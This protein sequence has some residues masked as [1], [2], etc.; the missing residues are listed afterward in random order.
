MLGSVLADVALMHLPDNWRWMVGLPVLP[1]AVLAGVQ[2][3]LCT[4]LPPIPRA[5]HVVSPAAVLAGWCPQA[6]HAGSI[7]HGWTAEHTKATVSKLT[8]KHMQC[9]NLSCLLNVAWLL[10]TAL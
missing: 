4:L 9:W 3:K 6:Q 10:L 7:R 8:V 5:L 2:C 1:A